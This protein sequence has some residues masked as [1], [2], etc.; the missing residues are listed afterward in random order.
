MP[1]ISLPFGSPDWQA[2]V[3]NSPPVRTIKSRTMH[4][5]R[6][7]PWLIC[8][9]R[10]GYVESRNELVGLLALEYLEMRGLLSFHKEQ[11]FTTPIALW[12]EGIAN[13]TDRKSHQYT[14]D[15]YARS[16]DGDRFVIEVKS[17]R[18]VSRELEACCER[19][20]EIFAE[21]GLKYLLWT[22][23]TPLVGHLR[24][25]LLR[26]RRAAVQ[27]FEQDE[28][29]RLVQILQEKGPLPVWALYNLDID[30]D[31]IAYATWLGKAHFPLQGILSGNTQISLETADDLAQHLLGIEPDMYRWWNSLEVAA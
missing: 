29:S 27:R 11:P 2:H 9:N 15:F 19:W 10:L 24:H 1:E 17:A 5:H 4:T 6:H 31:L 13:L 30:L 14:P 8:R 25:N 7:G 23:R 3:E 28:I 16:P 20:K 18:F 21:Y 26:L 22:D 12:E